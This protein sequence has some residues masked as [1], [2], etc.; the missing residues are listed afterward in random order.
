MPQEKK[1]SFYTECEQLLH[2]GQLHHQAKLAV[3]RET[4]LQAAYSTQ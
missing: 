1:K 2:L 3:W 4:Y